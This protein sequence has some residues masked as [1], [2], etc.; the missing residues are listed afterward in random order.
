VSGKA[1][2]LYIGP[3]AGIDEAGAACELEKV[4]R[5]RWRVSVRCALAAVGL[6]AVA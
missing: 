1:L 6:A 3:Q 4:E 2:S 5:E